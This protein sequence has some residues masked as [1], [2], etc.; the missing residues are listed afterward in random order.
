MSSYSPQPQS[1]GSTLVG[2]RDQI[3]ANFEIIR[4][5][6]AINHVAYDETGEGK[7]KFMQMPESGADFDNNDSAPSTAANEGALYTKEADSV[8]NLFF[9]QE[10][11]GAEI[12]LTSSQG[13]TN[14]NPGTTFLPGGLLMQFGSFTGAS[15]ADT[16]VTFNVP[17]GTAPYSVVVTMNR[18]GSNNVDTFYAHTLTTTN[19]QARNT[20]SSNRIGYYIAI[21]SAT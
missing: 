17:F 12:Q 6:F 20:S 16:T 7:H 1:K 21:G 8:T 3:R 11:D 19:F 13:A 10:S 18:E 15:K 5:D 4:D 9:R 2:T 14:A